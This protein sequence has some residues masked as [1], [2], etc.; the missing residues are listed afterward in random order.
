MVGELTIGPAPHLGTAVSARV[1][2]P[3][4]SWPAAVRAAGRGLVETGAAEGRYVERCVAQVEAD[5]PYIV[6]APGIALAHA[7]PE[8]GAAGLGV[9][10]AVLDR[11]VAFGHAV[12]DPVDVVFAF[13]SPDR[14]SH[15]GLLSA[16]ARQLTA[17]LAERLRVAPDDGRATELLQ[18][19][20][21]H[22]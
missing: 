11:P 13:C 1:R 15:V 5:G 8:D 19:A 10:V 12:N 18:E 6:V 9:S 14:D 4:G 17:G 22:G 16:L 7:R 21:G 20:I 3:A 2:V